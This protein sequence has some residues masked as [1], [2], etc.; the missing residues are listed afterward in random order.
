MVVAHRRA[1]LDVI[2]GEELV[3]A[4]LL[5]GLVFRVLAPRRERFQRFELDHRDTLAVLVREVLVRDITGHRGCELIHALAELCEGFLIH[6]RLETC[7]KHYD[8]HDD[9]SRAPGLRAALPRR[10]TISVTAASRSG[11]RKPR[12]R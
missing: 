5:R 7:A 6:F 1:H 4:A 10:S 11:L 2:L 12:A 8:D 9:S 3:A